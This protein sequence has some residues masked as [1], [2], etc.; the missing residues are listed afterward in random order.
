MVKVEVPSGGWALAVALALGLQAVY[1][2][3]TL[4]DAV[5]D[6]RK[7]VLVWRTMHRRFTSHRLRRLNS[8]GDARTSHF[9]WKKG[10]GVLS[11][12]S[13]SSGDENNSNSSSGSSSGRSSNAD[14]TDG[15]MSSQKK[16]V[17]VMVG[18]PARGKS[19]VVHKATR[20]I[21]WLGFPTRMFNV[22]N[23]RRQL[24]KAGEDATFF[25]ADN[26]DAT[27]LR[28]D[29]AMEVLDELIDWLETKGHVAIFDA[30]NTT[31]L[32]R[33]H[34]LDKVKSHTNIRV[35]FVESI[36][37]NEQLLDGNY[38]RYG[39]GIHP[40]ASIVVSATFSRGSCRSVILLT[41]A[42]S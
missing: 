28:E 13:D 9:M 23:L 37:D 10:P 29:M 42:E 27:Q 18:L 33:K 16:L 31:K 14:T 20:Y 24:G 4:L 3:E 17:L 38:R 26:P 40:C 41:S 32:R 15:L 19:F 11:D 21:E 8:L 1:Y 36:C 25:S 34:I 5:R 39:P 30:T 6:V 2:H 7:R 35:M 22:G 12:D